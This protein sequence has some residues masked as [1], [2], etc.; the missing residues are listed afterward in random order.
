MSTDT[1][2]RRRFEDVAAP[3]TEACLSQLT[4]WVLHADAH[5]LHYGLELPGMRLEPAG[6][7]AHRD[8]CL[9]HLALFGLDP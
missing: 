4:A 1:D 2:R 5:G 6:G 7:P 8:A 9:R 3:G